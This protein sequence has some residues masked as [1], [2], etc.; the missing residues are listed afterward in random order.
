[1]KK[2]I[3]VLLFTLCLGTVFS[4]CGKQS[5]SSKNASNTG[6][7]PTKGN[8]DEKT[9]EELEN[10]TASG[11]VAEFSDTGCT[12]VLSEIDDNEGIIVY[13]TG[14]DSSDENRTTVVYEEKVEFEIA[15]L[16]TTEVRYS[17]KDGNKEDIK[18]GTVVHL[19]G[20]E[21]EDGSILA[22]KV[23]IEQ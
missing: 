11:V 10:A 20:E 8:T 14:A 9:L 7:G 22:S 19:Y 5:D 13:G 21:Q 2:G 1:M 18:K 23:I 15:N 4:G 16:D 17:L 12:V 3:I 6:G